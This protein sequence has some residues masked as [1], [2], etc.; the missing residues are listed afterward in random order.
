MSR[1]HSYSVNNTVLIHMQNPH[2][3]LVA[4]FNRWR[5]QFE[6]HVKRG[7]KAI[8]IIAPV[9][10]KKN[11]TREKLDPDT[12]APVIGPDGQVVTENVEITIPRFRAVPVFDVSQTDGKPLP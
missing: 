9:P 2:A 7:E 5:D 6:R 1:F 11:V 8:R 3:T 4:G 10:Y 12:K